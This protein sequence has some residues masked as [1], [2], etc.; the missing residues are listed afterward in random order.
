MKYRV[1]TFMDAS[2]ATSIPHT[3]AVMYCVNDELII[4]ELFKDTIPMSTLKE[5]INESRWLI[6]EGTGVVDAI[7]KVNH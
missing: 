2:K 7:I 6:D 1:S 3:V 5:L 4:G